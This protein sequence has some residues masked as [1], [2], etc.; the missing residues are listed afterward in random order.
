MAVV[1]AI[2]QRS[3][4]IFVTVAKLSVSSSISD[5][6]WKALQYN[7]NNNDHGNG[8]SGTAVDDGTQRIYIMVEQ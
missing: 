2:F 5:Q 8:C 4:S 1:P 6:K 7:Q 3:L